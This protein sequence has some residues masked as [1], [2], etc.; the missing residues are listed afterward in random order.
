[1]PTWTSHRSMT[2][3]ICHKLP[4]WTSH[5]KLP[6]PT[7]HRLPT[8]TWWPWKTVWKDA[9]L[10]HFW[11]SRLYVCVICDEIFVI[12]ENYCLAKTCSIKD[13]GNILHSIWWAFKNYVDK[14]KGRG[15]SK[16][17]G[18]WLSMWTRIWRKNFRLKLVHI[19]VST[20]GGMGGQN[21]VKIGPC[22]C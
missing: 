11:Q 15:V 19:Y 5:N 6:T 13:R 10:W 1:M 4:T 2:S 14:K 3:Q 18:P 21:W 20:R 12:N 16:K 17:G 7:S 22:S 8:S 9:K